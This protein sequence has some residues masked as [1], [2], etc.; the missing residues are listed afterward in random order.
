MSSN[1]RRN[2]AYVP[3]GCN[4]ADD[5]AVTVLDA[6]QDDRTELLYLRALAYCAR[7]PQTDGYISQIALDAG[8]VLRRKIPR[9][10]VDTIQVSTEKLVDLG[11]WTREDN[12][13]RIT[14]WLKWN[15]SW[16]EISHGRASDAARKRPDVRPESSRTPDGFRPESS[17]TPGGVVTP[18]HSTAVHSTAVQDTAVQD[19]AAAEPPG[20][21]DFYDAFPKHIGRKEA[22]KAYRKALKDTDAS[23]LTDAAV[24]F[25]AHTRT[26]K[27]ETDFIP[28]PTTWLNQG[29]WQ[30]ELPKP[31][32]RQ[33]QPG[34]LG[35][36]PHK[37]H[38]LYR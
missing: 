20:F 19:T 26:C 8:R 2:G 16:D 31:V 9:N 15:R 1:V 6:A 3:L 22:V 33:P 18:T 23:V 17:R 32:K 28:M 4:F 13:Y 14:K 11:L 36:D 10:G 25:A 30:D 5:D 29:R 12:G 21:A 37:E 24:R 34:E 38:L 27:T 7:T 35:Y